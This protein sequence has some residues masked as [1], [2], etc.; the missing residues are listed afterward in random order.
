MIVAPDGRQEIRAGSI[1]MRPRFLQAGMAMLDV[2]V[3]LLLLAIVLTGAC[4]T[5]V[6]TMRQVHGAL[7]TTRAADLAAD[8]AE[9]LREVISAT[10][11]DAAVAAW[12]TRV[13]S[14]LPI[15]GLLPEESAS[16]RQVQAISDDSAVEA[17]SAYEVTLRWRAL[18]Q[19]ETASLTLP[20]AILPERPS[21]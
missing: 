7:L 10:Q 21:T 14:A 11:A 15:G 9:E 19:G 18:P 4:A 6:Q 20:V 13:A 17:G 1:S 5:L 16:L 12:R 3:A 8:L 2:L